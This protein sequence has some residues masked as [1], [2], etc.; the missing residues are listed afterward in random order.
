MISIHYIYLTIMTEL[1]VSVIV[2]MST[3]VEEM[4]ATLEE[5]YV[6]QEEMSTTVKEIEYVLEN[7]RVEVFIHNSA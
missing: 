7:L 1:N 5:M 3:T 6:T 4:S 2:Q